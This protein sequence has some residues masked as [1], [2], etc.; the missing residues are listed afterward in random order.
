[1]LLILKELELQILVYSLQYLQ[2]AIRKKRKVTIYKTLL[3]QQLLFF[4]KKFC[5]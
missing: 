3:E 1:M 4:L 5:F 2:H